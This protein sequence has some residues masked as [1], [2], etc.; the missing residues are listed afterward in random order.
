M[1]RARRTDGLKEL[2]SG[3]RVFVTTFSFLLKKTNKN[4][5]SDKEMGGTTCTNLCSKKK[6]KTYDATN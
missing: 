3:I 6:L 4:R 2:P 5:K 1:L